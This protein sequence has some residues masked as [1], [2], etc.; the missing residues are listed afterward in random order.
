[1]SEVATTGRTRTKN[2]AKL[3]ASNDEDFRQSKRS[4][5]NALAEKKNNPPSL[6]SQTF[7]NYGNCLSALGRSFEV[8]YAYRSALEIE[9]R[10]G[11]AAGNLG[12]ELLFCPD[13]PH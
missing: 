6:R 13:V 8:I 11:M 12:I 3:I 9:L 1:M 5:R 4:Y 2:G 10:N 7:V